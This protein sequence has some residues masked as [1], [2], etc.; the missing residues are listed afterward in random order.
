[1]IKKLENDMKFWK[2]KEKETE[3]CRKKSA[4]MC[5]N[6]MWKEIHIVH[7]SRCEKEWIM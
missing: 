6:H 3:L 2:K 1:M 5:K 7:V 4:G